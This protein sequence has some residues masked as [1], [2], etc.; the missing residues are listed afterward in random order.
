MTD[1]SATIENLGTEAAFRV[2]MFQA[3]TEAKYED[4]ALAA[5]GLAEVV[6]FRS[7][8][9]AM[10]CA[11]RA[12]VYATLHQA[13]VLAAVFPDQ[14]PEALEQ[15]ARIDTVEQL[16]ALP[17]GSVI[18]CGDDILIRSDQFHG[19][20]CWRYNPD[21]EPMFLTGDDLPAR[22]LYRPEET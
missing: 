14:Y 22:V 17:L 13:R 20:L 12:Q 4:A 7:P 1:P 10:Y 9:G 6:S 21:S 2:E 8:E 5:L 19:G 18:R 15:A 16:D 11:Q 3:E